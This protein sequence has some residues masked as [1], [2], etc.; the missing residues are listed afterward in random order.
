MISER[1]VLGFS[2]I[3]NIQ[4][5]LHLVVVSECAEVCRPIESLPTRANHNPSI[6]FELKEIELIPLDLKLSGDSLQAI[7][8]I[9]DKIKKYMRHGFYFGHN[10]ELTM[11]AQ[12]RAMRISNDGVQQA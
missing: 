7:T 9:K 6:I 10:Y 3:L 12:K 4:Q 11:S 5:C 8:P 1:Q 2:G